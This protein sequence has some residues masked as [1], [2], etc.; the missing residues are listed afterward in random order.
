MQESLKTYIEAL[1]LTAE[2]RDYL[3]KEFRACLKQSK[4]FEF[5]YNRT[6]IDK[7]AIK[8]ILNASITEIETQKKIIEESKD[9]INRTLTEVDKQHKLIEIKNKELHT[10]LRD[11]KEAQ[12]QLVMSEKMASLGQLTAGVAHEINNPINFVSANI[13]PLKEDLSDIIESIHAYEKV[14]AEN[15]LEAFFAKAK[16]DNRKKDLEFTLLEVQE[17][18]K[19]I[20]EGAHRTSEIVKGLRNFSRL[21]QNVVKNTNIN[22]GLES[23]LAI[24]HSSFKDRVTVVK[25]YGNIPEITCLP[26][27][28]NQVFMNILSNAIQAIE[29]TGSIFITTESN[30]DDV[31]I[32]IRDT[33]S[34]M[35]EAVKQKIFEPFFTTK[36][37]GKGTGLGLSISYGIVKKHKGSI[38]VISEIGQG[39]TFHIQLPIKQEKNTSLQTNTND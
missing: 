25:D 30:G 9:E 1:N 29:G 7:T 23:T 33:G 11:L 8:N 13:K 32:K 39:T 38:S 35:P 3:M 17:L 21:D 19:G 10:L 16:E 24:L 36:D 14:I 37:V 31:L 15:E 34:G 18:L 2:E 27:E 22:E 6:L 28:I 26:G 20:E 4:A 12:Q 5:Q